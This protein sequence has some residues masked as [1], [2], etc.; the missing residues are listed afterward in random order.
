MGDSS[1]RA[2]PNTRAASVNLDAMT[3]V[4]TSKQLPLEVS[5]AMN[6]MRATP[7]AATD[8]LRQWQLIPEDTRVSSEALT[9]G[10]L[11]FAAMPKAK[12]GAWAIEVICAFAVYAQ[13]VRADNLATTVWERLK[14][15]MVI[16]GE[17]HE[18]LE[19]LKRQREEQQRRQEELLDGQE[20]AQLELVGA[21]GTLSK[22]IRGLAE[23]HARLTKELDAVRTLQAELTTSLGRLDATTTRAEAPQPMASTAPTARP[24]YAATVMHVLP[25]SHATSIARQEAQF[26]KVLIDI[27]KTDDGAAAAAPLTAAEYV[28]KA[29]VALDLMRADNHPPPDGLRFLTVKR[30]DQGGLLYEVNTKEGA[31]WLQRPENMRHFTDKFGLDAVIRAKYYACLVR[32]APTHLRPE[33]EQTLHDMERENGWNKGEVVAAHWIKPVAKRR[34]GQERAHLILK[35]STPQRAN[36]TIMN[37][38]SIMGLRL[39]VEKLRKEARRCLRCQKLEPGHMARDCDMIEDVCGTCGGLHTTQECTEDTRRCVNCQTTDHAS[40]DR[41]CPAFMEAT[42]KVQKANTLERYRFF[43][44]AD[45]PRTWDHLDGSEL[46]PRHH[47]DAPDSHRTPFSWSDD[48]D[49]HYNKRD[50]PPNSRYRRRRRSRSRTRSQ[51][52]EGAMRPPTHGANN[53]PLGPERGHHPDPELPR[54]PRTYSMQETPGWRQ[55]T[56]TLD[57]GLRLFPSRP[58]TPSVSHPSPST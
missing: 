41:K 55:T 34:P 37:G 33:N 4:P 22:E 47:L 10:L 38:L 50:V 58:R 57:G 26:R 56:L 51:S 19:E 8:C 40:W 54:R 53:T 29:M 15:A 43:P 25:T 46:P 21:V 3:K 42:R 5:N 49:T 32:N 14:P 7:D 24:S 23:G 6:K 52:P 30:L 2:T 11:H 44:M 28:Q 27:K 31:S 16:R 36:E 45:D 17:Q 13:D 9:T 48:A 1:R 20:R 39:P 35:L 18:D 12:L